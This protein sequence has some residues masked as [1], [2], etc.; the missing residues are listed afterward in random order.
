MCFHDRLCTLESKCLPAAC[1]RKDKEIP[2]YA[3]SMHARSIAC[4]SSAYAPEME[5]AT[6]LRNQGAIAT[7][8]QGCCH[9]LLKGFARQLTAAGRTTLGVTHDAG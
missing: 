4:R 7:C 1:C 5:A 9:A 2:T 6:A 3:P 8:E